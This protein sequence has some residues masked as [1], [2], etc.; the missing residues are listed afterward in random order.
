[1][2][3]NADNSSHQSYGREIIEVEAAALH[4]L[5]ESLNETFDQAIELIQNT[6]GRLVISGIGKSGHVGKKIAA[7]FASTGQPSFFVH[8]AEAGH[9]DLGMIT[10]EDTLLLISYSGE[11]KELH[12]IIDYAHRFSIPIISI[13]GRANCNLTRVATLSLILP[14]VGEA[15]PMGLAPTTSTTMTMALGDA[16]AVALLRSRG[17][18]K[19]DFKMFHPGGNLGQQLKQ[20]IEYMHTGEKVPLVA[21]DTLMSE[22]LVKMTCHGF[23]CVGVIDQNKKLIGVI[24]DG[25]LRRHMNANMLSQKADE[26]MTANPVVGHND[27]LMADALAIFEKKSITSLFIVDQ[28]KNV[29]GLLH[30]HDCLRNSV[31]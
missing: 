11:A 15:C 3:V 19:H 5:A 25:D 29:L 21:R 7:T 14:N 30:I 8:A 1:M 20:I 2:I 9:G 17:F 10:K 16:L 13:T 31:A 4:Q 27:L 24:T 12:A 23:G 26:I 28:E 22:C 18:S 6:K